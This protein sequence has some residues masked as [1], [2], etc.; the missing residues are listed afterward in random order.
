MSRDHSKL[1]VFQLADDL[2]LRVYQLT[3]SFSVG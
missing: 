2:V 3:G 1:K